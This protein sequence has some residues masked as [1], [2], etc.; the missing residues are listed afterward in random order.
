[1]LRDTVTDAC[2]NELAAEIAEVCSA[3]GYFW[4]IPQTSSYSLS[5]SSVINVF[6]E[7]VL[8]PPRF[9]R[10]GATAVGWRRGVVVSGV[11]RMSEVNARRARLLTA[12]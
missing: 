7:A 9:L 1:M 8:H 3:M 5:W 4:L 12:R 10:P 6:G 2:L 11:R